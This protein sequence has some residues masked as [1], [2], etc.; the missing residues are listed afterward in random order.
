MTMNTAIRS[1]ETG[2]DTVVFIDS[3][4]RM[5][6]AFNKETQS[7]GRTLTGGLGA[8]A[9][10]MPRRIFGAARNIENGGSLTIIATILIKTGRKCAE[11]RLWPAININ[12][13]GTRKE[14]LLLDTQEF[15]EMVELRRGLSQKDEIT[16]MSAFIEYLGQ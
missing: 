12:Q 3:L 13:S 8:N 4:T 9:M 6:R 2:I 14:H 10:E 15:Q 7:Y 5:S 11:R 16:A 1:A